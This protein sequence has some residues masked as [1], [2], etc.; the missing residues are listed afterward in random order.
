MSGIHKAKCYC[1]A[2]EWQV[3]GKPAVSGYCHCDT[4]KHWFATTMYAACIFKSSQF[5]VLKGDDKV[6]SLNTGE[7]DRYW[8]T[9]CGSRTYAIN[10]KDGV[11]SLPFTQFEEVSCDGFPSELGMGG[12]IFYEERIY[13]I[14]D[15]KAKICGMPKPKSMPNFAVVAW[16]KEFIPWFLTV[17]LMG[18]IGWSKYFAK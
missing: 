8:C 4:C 16:M 9:E 3:E 2:V 11:C 13:D 10:K 5:K 7:I 15:G 17:G 1:G 6:K 18:Y 12:H 14:P